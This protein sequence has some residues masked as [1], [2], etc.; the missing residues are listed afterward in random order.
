MFAGEPSILMRPEFYVTAGA[1]SA[2]LTVPLLVA[3]LPGALVG[4]L[5]FLAGFALR[6]AAIIRGWSLPAYGRSLGEAARISLYRRPTRSSNLRASLAA[7]LRVGNTQLQRGSKP[8]KFMLILATAAA[9]AVPAEA[10]QP[11]PVD[12]N[13]A[14]V[15]ADDAAMAAAIAF[16]RSQL[17]GFFTRLSDPGPGESNFAVKFN[18]ARSG[19]F[20]WAGDLRRENGRLTGALDNQPIHAGYKL[21]QRV[22]IPEADII[23]WSYRRDAVTQGHHTTRV[24]LGQIDPAHAAA[25]R[26]SLGW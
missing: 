2:A 16:A 3:G 22:S 26:S 6:G 4:P 8:M 10:T 14:M 21:G 5:A 13:V 11:Q 18:L 9:F 7:R 23:D 25:V 15:E 1:L 24:L 20:I 19:E 12:K 17:A